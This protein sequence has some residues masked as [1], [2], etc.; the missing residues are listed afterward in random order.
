MKTVSL[1][2][3]VCRLNVLLY[4]DNLNTR[5]LKKKRRTARSTFLILARLFYGPPEGMS[6]AD[7]AESLQLAASYVSN[8]TTELEKQGLVKRAESKARVGGVTIRLTA[9]GKV[10]FNDDVKQGIREFAQF[11][12]LWDSAADRNDALRLLQTVVTRLEHEVR[13]P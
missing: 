9:Q 8:L 12:L 4:L 1:A 13:S 10:R 5:R 3:A 6:Q 7:L 11:D 2:E